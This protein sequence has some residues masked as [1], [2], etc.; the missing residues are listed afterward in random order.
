VPERLAHRR[1]VVMAFLQEKG[2]ESRAYFF[3]PV[4]EQR[5]FRRYADRPLPHTE[6]LAR[7][8][9]TLPFYSGIADCEMNY[10]IA[11]LAEAERSLA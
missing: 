10:V 7:R 11:A 2:I 6:K 4:H 9:L 1:D 5:F 3:P 8:V